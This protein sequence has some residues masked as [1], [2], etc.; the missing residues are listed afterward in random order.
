ME[1][2]KGIKA[3]TIAWK[4]YEIEVKQRDLVNGRISGTFVGRL[5]IMNDN[6]KITMKDLFNKIESMDK[7]FEKKFHSMDKKFESIDKKIESIDK[8]IDL[9]LATPTIQREIDHEALSK[10]S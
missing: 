8:K 6:K 2:I 3:I 7:K 5:K 4:N 1:N 10:L 9:I